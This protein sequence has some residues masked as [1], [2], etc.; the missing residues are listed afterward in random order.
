VKA[1]DQ[2]WRRWSR[3]SDSNLKVLGSEFPRGHSLAPANKANS[4]FTYVRLCSYSP[5]H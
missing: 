4:Q 1:E 2:C 5:A 3:F